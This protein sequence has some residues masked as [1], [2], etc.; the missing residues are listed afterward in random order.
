LVR[1]WLT[2]SSALELKSILI[3]PWPTR[4]SLA[5]RGF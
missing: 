5:I 2:T 3:I 4:Q 1:N